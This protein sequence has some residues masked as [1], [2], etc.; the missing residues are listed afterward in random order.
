MVGT[1]ASSPAKLDISNILVAQK[2]VII[3]TISQT[4]QLT[5]A[6]FDWRLS[7]IDKI[8]KESGIDVVDMLTEW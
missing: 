1:D 7:L 4:Q 6:A 5:L 3:L 8:I 2:F